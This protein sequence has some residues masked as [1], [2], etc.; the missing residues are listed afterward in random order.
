M[1]T[2][3]PLPGRRDRPGERATAAPPTTPAWCCWSRCDGV[4]ILLTGRRRAARP[5]ARWPACLAGLDVDVLKV[6]HHGS[7]HQDLDFLLG[8]RA[9]LALVSV[10]ADNDYGHPDPP[11]L[12]AALDRDGGA[13]V[14]A[15]TSTATC[16]WPRRRCARCPCPRLGWSHHGAHPHRSAGPRPGHP[17]HR[18]GGVPQRAHRRRRPRRRRATTPRPRSPTPTRPT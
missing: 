14:R 17:R 8:L 12:L 15:P 16:W 10:G 5:G 13:V 18:Q 6:P 11:D 3:W 4:R 9:R 1:Q 2:L 7:R